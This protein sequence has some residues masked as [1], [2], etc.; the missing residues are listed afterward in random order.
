M[1]KNPKKKIKIMAKNKS[2]INEA[3]SP[4]KDTIISSVVNKR[5]IVIYYLGD[6]ETSPGWRTI[7]PVYYGA[8]TVKDGTKD[9]IRAWQ[10][11]GKTISGIPKWK[12]FRTD[13]IRNWNLSSNL[14]FDRPP[15]PRYN[16]NDDAW[17]TGGKYAQADFTPNQEDKPED[18]IRP[19]PNKPKTGAPAKNAPSKP[20]TGAMGAEPKNVP[21]GVKNTQEKPKKP[22]KGP[23]RPGAKKDDTESI[24]EDILNILYMIV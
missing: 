3:F 6:D 20:K 9:Y 8:R 10:N 14:S 16:P 13:R 2:T 4:S 11:K 5:V 24:K 15:D 21:G 7:L 19:T 18:P 22:L 23:A 12:L 17:M 1:K